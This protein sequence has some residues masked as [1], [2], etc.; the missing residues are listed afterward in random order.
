MSFNELGLAPQ[1]L[2]AVAEAG[3]TTPTPIQQQAIP[4]VLEGKDVMGGAQTGTGKT[5]GFGLPILHKLLPQANTSPSPA[6]H[7][8]RAL[9]LTPTRELA[10]Q[11]EEAI[12][13]YGKYTNLRS[14]VVF[15]GVDIKQQLPIVR[16]G[17]EILV[18]T[19]GRLL[20]HIEQKSVY[21]GQVEIF[22]LDEAD[23]M[24]DMGFIPDIKR[25]MALLPATA[26]RQNLLFSA[27]FSGEIKKLADELLNE[28]KLIEVARRNTAAETVDQSAYKVK[29]EDKRALLVHLVTSRNLWQVLC[30]VR[31]KHGAS[32]LARQLEKDG[33][34][35]S[36][37]HGDKTQAARLEAL[38]SFKEGKLQVL[39]ATDVAAR[40]LDIDNLPV[41][42]N[43][44]LPHT[45][46]DYIHRIGRTGRAGLSGVAI[47]LVDPAET[48][49]LTEIEKLVRKKVLVH[50][51]EPF[52]T[53]RASSSPVARE[54]KARRTRAE[55]PSRHARD[56]SA[57]RAPAAPRDRQREREE[58][59]AKNPDQPL[60]RARAPL[61]KERTV[62]MLLK[63]LPVTGAE[64]EKVPQ[65]P[66][67]TT[68]IA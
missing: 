58:A 36:A 21:L 9:I 53:E 13:E 6:R 46:E 10:I 24:L 30:F 52:A 59:Y 54:D 28:P 15:G 55:R 29:Q 48:K 2:R 35:T 34:K 63:K 51:P 45:P 25:I 17:V 61:A 22:V 7:P 23:R 47:S 3:Y 18:A 20:D 39:V 57:Q 4:V 26:K 40:G 1:L 42:V 31:T 14:T 68:T 49:Y 32:R 38:A 16:N 62:P 12:R 66:P 19:P 64:P 11:V 67:A 41:V 44:E 33:L 65:G 56:E 60:Q 50:E 8:V 37:I 5:A 43:F 27:T